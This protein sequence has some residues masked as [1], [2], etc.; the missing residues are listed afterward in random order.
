MA[1]WWDVVAKKD[2]RQRLT[3]HLFTINGMGVGWDFGPQADIARWLTTYTPYWRWDAIQYNASPF[4]MGMYVDQAVAGLENQ[5]ALA[6]DP[7]GVDEMAW[8]I[9]SQGAIAGCR[10]YNRMKAGT[11]PVSWA[12]D[13]LKV[14]VT[15]GN[16]CREKGK[17][18]GNKYAG[19]DMPDATSR[20][21]APAN[22]RVV[23]T[24]DW[25][26]DFAHRGDIY[27]DTPDGDVPGD[28]NNLVGQDMTM[29]YNIV[30]DPKFLIMGQDS[31]LE[32]VMQIMESPLKEIPAAAIAIFH[33]IGFLAAPGGPTFPHI[34]YDV[35]PAIRLL[36]DFGARVPIAM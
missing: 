19:W 8:I 18:N 26:Y 12:L 23:D 15:Y 2:G 34:N 24:P 31:A 9:Y 25:W 10:V 33:G 11:S 3:R 32:Q 13:R 30:Q 4:P 36:N 29:I 28:L 35:G 21:I 5:I 16:P 27:T 7:N 6:L 17:A 14:V 22:Q 20:G 1:D